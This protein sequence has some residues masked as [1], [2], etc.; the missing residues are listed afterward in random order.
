MQMLC[1]SFIAA[2]NT[3]FLSPSWLATHDYAT[4]GWYAFLGAIG[5][6]F[7]VYTFLGDFLPGMGGHTQIG[8]WTV[9]LESRQK[10]LGDIRTIRDRLLSSGAEPDRLEGLERG[11]QDYQRD[12]ERLESQI[13]KE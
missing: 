13:S 12:I 8:N 2:A 6:V 11:G 3:D 5:A 4:A 1:T 9:E 7:A 10:K